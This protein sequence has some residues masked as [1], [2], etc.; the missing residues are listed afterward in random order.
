M[1]VENITY[2]VERLRRRFH[3]DDP[4]RLCEAMN[5]IVARESMG[6]Y[7]GACKGFF[8]AQSRKRLVM[9][10]AD[11]PAELQRVIAAHELGHAVLHR[12]ALG[13]NTFH[14]F[15]L[16]NNTSVMEYEANMFAAEYLMPDVEVLEKLN[17]DLS[18]FGAAA[19][20]RV[21]PEL[22][23]FKF[24]LLKRKGYKVVDPPFHCCGDFLKGVGFDGGSTP[25]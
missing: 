5:I 7:P 2:E 23:D 15:A 16:F 20:L 8:L 18:F 12:K 22:L 19:L 9:I 6:T 24:R 11:L 14:D 1:T 10:N 25:D 21:P 4:I 17:D 13:I 3:E